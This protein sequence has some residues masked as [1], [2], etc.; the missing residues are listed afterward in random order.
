MGHS[1]KLAV[2]KAKIKIKNPRIRAG[3]GPKPTISLGKCL[4]RDSPGEGGAKNKIKNHFKHIQEKRVDTNV[5][6]CPKNHYGTK[7]TLHLQTLAGS[8]PTSESEK[9]KGVGTSGPEPPP[10]NHPPA[11]ITHTPPTLKEILL[12]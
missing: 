3:I 2:L 4:P 1:Q 5:K 11:S 10:T 7:C 9:E 6:S 8:M 12:G